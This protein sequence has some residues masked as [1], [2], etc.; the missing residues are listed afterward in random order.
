MKVILFI[1][2][3]IPAL[4]FSQPLGGTKI[5]LDIESK[6][7]GCAPAT[8]STFLELN[9]V[10]ALVHTAGNLW[11]ISGQN[12]SHYEVPKNSGIMALFASALWLGGKD[13][14]GQLK[15]AAL[16]YRNGNDYWTGPLSQNTAEITPEICEKYDQH[17][18]TTLDAINE[19]NTWYELGEQDAIDG[20]TLQSELY[21]NYVVPKMI[22][23]W[24]AH[25]D[26]S[27]GQDYYLAP[28]YDR[29]EDG[30]YQWEL[31]DYP[32]YDI[33]NEID[34]KTDRT[35]S[36]FGDE[37]IWWVIN[38]KGN[39]HTESGG[40]PIGMEI[41]AQA[42]G[43]A[44]NDEVNNMTFYNYEL[45][46]RSTQTLYDTYFG[47]MIDVA[48]GGPLD[49]YVGC[50][51]NRG[52][53]Y[54]YNGDNIDE[55][56][57]GYLG[58]GNNPPAV[59]VD[60]F[61][62]PYQDDDGIDNAFG[63]GPNEALNGIGYG[64]TIIDNERFGMRRFLY[65]NNTGGGADP[66]TTDPIS[67]NDYYNFL[68]GFWKD[69]TNFLYGGSGHQSDSDAD[70][71]TTA[72]FMFPGDTDP[73]GWG[74]NGV[75]QEPWTEQTAGNPPYDRRFAQ[76]A[77][78]FVLKP[79][80]V[81][82]ITMGVVWARST[83]GDPFA[84]VELLRK[85]DD[86]AQ[87]L[88]ENCFRVIEGPHA[89][90]LNIQEL[91]N[92][93]I[94]TLT[95]PVNSNNANENYS[96]IDPF[97]VSIDSGGVDNV[98]RFQGYQVYQVSG[99][100]VSVSD[101]GNID[102]ARL[103]FQCDLQDSIERLVNFEFDEDLLAAIP[104]EKVDGENKGLKHSFS[105][106][107][108]QFAT[109]V[110]TLVNFKRYY[111]IAVAYAHNEY[112]KYVPDDADGIFGQKKPYLSSRKAAIGEVRTIEGIPHSPKPEANGTSQ[113]VDYG[114]EFPITRVDGAGN[115]GR[116][117]DLTQTSIDQ[118]VAQ[119]KVDR[120][121]YKANAGPVA[122][123]CIDPLNLAKGTFRLKFYPDENGETTNSSWTIYQIETGD[124]ITSN[125]TIRVTNEQLIPEWGISVQMEQTEYR[126]SGPL[127]QYTDLLDATISYADSS[128]RWLFGV[129]DND[130]DS[131]F[132][133]IRSGTQEVDA[134]DCDPS[135]GDLNPCNFGDRIGVDPNQTYEKILNGTVAP[136]AL[137]RTGFRGMPI[138]N[139]GGVNVTGTV[140]STELGIVRDVDIVLTS[141]KTKWTRCPVF[142]MGTESTL[143]N[144]PSEPWRL[145]NAPSKDINGNQESDTGFSWFPGYAIDINSG[146]R[147]HIGFGENS[148]LAQ[149]NGADMLWNPTSTFTDNTGEPLFGGMHV[150][151][152]F[153]ADLYN[154]GPTVYSEDMTYF[155]N[156]L[157]ETNITGTLMGHVFKSC[158]WVMYPTLSPGESLLASDAK[159]RLRVNRRYEEYTATNENGGFPLYEFSTNPYFTEYEREDILTE[160]LDLINVVP[161]PYNGYSSYETSKLD[162][163][164]KITNLPEVCTIRIYDVSGKLINS[165]K[166]DNP[167]TFQ[168][169]RLVNN[170]G[171]PVSSGV[172]LIHVEVP[173]IGETIVKSFISKRQ[174]DFQNF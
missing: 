76:S 67:A 35:V 92:E 71:Q 6:A 83:A 159:V 169:W 150:V 59:G 142:E 10:S 157:S 52:L 29:N 87:A 53:G 116:I 119:N 32:W 109:G 143:N 63:I 68:S 114:F 110:R 30:I 49:D 153:G 148:F 146:K 3:L 154:N 121:T 44:T 79:G 112:K 16:R 70:V 163:R 115:G 125:Q 13:I 140:N 100:E 106:S 25:G 93:L 102:Q 43:F 132:N 94:I 160:A 124:S 12:F 81:N 136:F 51:V 11:Q 173:G 8:T 41:R 133:W 155:T 127:I 82:N 47:L 33:E 117:I 170:T 167:L 40:D 36:I 80:A 27:L 39:I 73:L 18:T 58:Y 164:V 128:K 158:M 50:D 141:D 96:E 26:E 19:F 78:P 91:E 74:T 161:N 48:L 72:D 103:V 4:V 84:S 22:T 162:N 85:A 37:N 168:D 137:V 90:D 42:F 156:K 122:I 54:S 66:A 56:E 21:P 139:A 46:N 1:T 174:V 98:Y 7:A 9:N 62:G 77:G 130:Q 104:V 2:F 151:Y 28:F 61:E 171:I 65:Y 99:P 131:Y 123:K 34:C 111:Y 135:L 138:G 147:L 113:L 20:T 165:F 14:N 97:I 166:K 64:D 129:A 126:Y 23:E 5:S 24:P 31:G 17:Y 57:G 75:P 15:L 118:I 172:Y 60:F 45:I 108:D 55:D 86:K 145:R 107:E 101:L 38:D 88:F 105:V 95:N 152:V 69:N 134:A 120:I 89:P 149:E 144:G